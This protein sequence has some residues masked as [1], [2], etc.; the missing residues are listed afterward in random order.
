MSV[1]LSNNDFKKEIFDGKS[2]KWD[3]F[4]AWIK[5]DLSE[6]YTSIQ[7][8]L[9][10]KEKVSISDD[11]LVDYLTQLQNFS[12][13]ELENKG[14][15]PVFAVQI[16][17]KKLWYTVG[18][19]DWI[20]TM[21]NRTI[22]S[23]TQSSIQKFQW[24]VWLPT[25]WIIDTYTIWRI[26]EKFSVNQP[27]T[28][29]PNL[30][31][32]ESVKPTKIVDGVKQ[33]NTEILVDQLVQKNISNAVSDIDQQFIYQQ[34]NIVVDDLRTRI[35]TDKYNIAKDSHDYRI[36]NQIIGKTYSIYDDQWK[37]LLDIWVYTKWPLTGRTLI[38]KNDTAIDERDP[39]L[40]KYIRNLN[41]DYRSDPQ[42]ISSIS[43][44]L[45]V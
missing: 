3:I 16:A 12:T 30:P 7:E 22:L 20:A 8:S 39:N 21:K 43:K 40:P 10:N 18:T 6:L 45:S 11:Y 9:Q 38:I 37:T 34:M 24:D 17:L 25:T 26:I 2:D 4:E 31:Q 29:Y 27:N 32:T 23:Q 14:S 36:E 33:K 28:I 41:I 44:T 42:V 19:I 5:K 35:D 1:E 13:Q 15:G